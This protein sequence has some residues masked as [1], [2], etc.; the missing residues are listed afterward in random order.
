M[1]KRPVVIVIL[2]F[3]LICIKTQTGFDIRESEKDYFN[4]KSTCLHNVSIKIINFLDQRQKYVKLN[5]SQALLT[6]FKHQI[7]IAENLRTTFDRLQNITESNVTENS[8][9]LRNILEDIMREEMHNSK[10]YF[11]KKS[12]VNKFDREFAIFLNIIFNKARKISTKNVVK[13]TNRMIKSPILKTPWK[14]TRDIKVWR[15]LFIVQ[16]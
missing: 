13:I 1:Y 9:H 15:K 2:Y 14:R 4:S 7:H 3:N 11:V 12:S 10:N 6:M 16:I 8:L 5:K